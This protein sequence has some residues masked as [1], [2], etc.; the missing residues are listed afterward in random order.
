M[1]VKEISN[2]CDIAEVMRVCEVT[3]CVDY[4]GNKLGDSLD[5]DYDWC[6]NIRT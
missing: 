3:K 5:L 6:S 2:L 4:L 1:T